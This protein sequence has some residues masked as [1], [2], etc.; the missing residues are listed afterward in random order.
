MSVLFIAWCKVQT[1]PIMVVGDGDIITTRILLITV[2][3]EAG[4][5]ADRERAGCSH[6]NEFWEINKTN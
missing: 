3:N 6:G 5:K 4:R 1:N 2:T